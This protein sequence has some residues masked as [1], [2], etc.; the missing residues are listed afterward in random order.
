M[1][2]IVRENIAG[3]DITA[4]VFWLLSVGWR[5]TVARVSLV[6]VRRAL[7][8]TAARLA[9]VVAG[10]GG[11]ASAGPAARIG[12]VAGGRSALRRVLAALGVLQVQRTRQTCHSTQGPHTHQPISTR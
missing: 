9:A 10:G 6:A 2:D 8:L 12:A 5:L 11:G 1:Y 4:D 7:R 3:E